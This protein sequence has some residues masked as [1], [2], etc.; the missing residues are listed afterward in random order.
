M[1][2]KESQMIKEAGQ[3]QFLRMVAVWRMKG[4][5]NSGEGRKRMWGKVRTGRRLPPPNNAQIVNVVVYMN[6]IFAEFN[7]SGTQC[8][9][10]GR[11]SGGKKCSDV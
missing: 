4:S 5:G 6:E 1:L 10:V 3:T 7:L 8:S 11:R 2:M 9:L